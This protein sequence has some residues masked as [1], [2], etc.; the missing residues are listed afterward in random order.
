MEA[1]A[2]RSA[3]SPLGLLA[4]S[5]VLLGACSVGNQQEQFKMQKATLVLASGETIVG[6]IQSQ[7]KGAIGFI[8]KEGRFRSI[9]LRAVLFVKP[10]EEPKV[11]TAATVA[12]P[13]E[14]GAL[15]RFK[16]P[17][18]GRLVIPS[19]ERVSL[20]F[21]QALSGDALYPHQMLNAEI[22]ADLRSNP[23]AVPAGSR[24]TAE[25][26]EAP[27]QGRSDVVIGLLAININGHFYRPAGKKA[28]RLG[29]LPRPPNQS[30]ADEKLGGRGVRVPNGTVISWKIAQTVELREQK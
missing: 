6:T 3:S 23:T 29:T 25:V 11:E 9:P 21:N 20:I 26:L 22:T 16:P 24:A 13:V 7:N 8:T 4:L 15:E 17:A 27:L 28:I 18:A 14:P 30:D 2:H 5:G 1:A 19:G 10:V 12:A